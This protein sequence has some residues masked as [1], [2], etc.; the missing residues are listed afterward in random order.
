MKNTLVFASAIGLFITSTLATASAFPGQRFTKD[1]KVTLAQ[2]RT[3]ALHAVPG[4]KVM[5]Y[6]LEREA[7]GNGLQYDFE[8]KAG[9]QLR[10]IGVDAKSGKIIERETE[11]AGKDKD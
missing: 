10:D 6:E 2:A 1:A 9:A 5:K 7:G 3:I 8:I 4:G 11:H